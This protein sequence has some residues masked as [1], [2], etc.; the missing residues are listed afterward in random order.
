MLVAPLPLARLSKTSAD[1]YIYI[2]IYRGAAALEGFVHGGFA[3]ATRRAS[4]TSSRGV[5]RGRTVD[6]YFPFVNNIRSRTHKASVGYPE[7]PRD[8]RT[9]CGWRFGVS[10]VARPVLSLPACHKTICERSLK[11]ERE[12][13]RM[14]AE[15]KVLEVG[16]DAR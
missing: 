12:Q 6:A 9:V 4:S 7:P 5:S 3:A 2:Y 11:A 15:T 1:I 8:W 13:A 16:E 10:E 14:R